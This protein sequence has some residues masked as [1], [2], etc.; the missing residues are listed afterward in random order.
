MS[1][2]KATKPTL[3]VKT[4]SS[5]ITTSPT[6]TYDSID[7]KLESKS[8]VFEDKS[9]EDMADYVQPRPLSVA[10]PHTS[11]FNTTGPYCPRRPNLSDIQ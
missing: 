7:S 4:V 1:I 11:G 6:L 5:S 10:I 9:D 3:R 2:K 8:E